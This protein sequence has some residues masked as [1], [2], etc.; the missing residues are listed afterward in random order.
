MA[1]LPEPTSL[2]IEAIYRGYEA[3]ARGDGMREHLGASVVG[4]ECE[5]ALWYGF[6]W[7]TRV[8]HAGR[9]LRLFATGH[10]E[11]GRLVK[12]LRRAGVTVMEVDPATGRQWSVAACDGHF[13]G[14]MDAI[15]LGLHEAPKSYHLAEFKT[16][17]QKSFSALQK[18]GLE[19]SK[20]MHFAQMQVYMH[21]GQLDRGV[22]LAVNKNTDEIYLERIKP[23]P[24][25]AARLLAKAE[26]V[27]KVSEPPAKLS[28]DPEYWLCRFCDHK[29]LCHGEAL[30]ERNCRTCINSTP[31]AE[32]KWHCASQDA[33]LTGPQQRRGCMTS[34]RYLPGLVAGEQV[35]VRGD[36]IVYQMRDGAEW[37]DAGT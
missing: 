19:K 31:I 1:L 11:E 9:L 2:T 14:S 37:V 25:L 5:R 35:D 16:H 24:V 20:P 30:A 34:H 6:R 28:D 8:R 12:D 21:L 15:V 7:A 18:H 10:L 29:D 4:N 17:N 3:S 27:I 32:G 22:Y 26:R 36:A 33:V 23:D 13:G